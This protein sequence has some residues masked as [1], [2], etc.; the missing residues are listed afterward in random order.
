MAVA[1]CD[2]T[3]AGGGW[4]PVGAYPDNQNDGDNGTYMSWPGDTA[5]ATTNYYDHTDVPDGAVISDVSVS[6]LWSAGS[7]AATC[8]YTCWLSGNSTNLGTIGDVA[9]YSSSISRPGGGTWTKTDVQNMYI[10]WTSLQTGNSNVMRLKSSA[11]TV[12][13]VLSGFYVVSIY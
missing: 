13:Y 12:T 10:T 5:G 9:S 11:L 6:G 8:N 3:A 4:T 2:V 7:A 1:T